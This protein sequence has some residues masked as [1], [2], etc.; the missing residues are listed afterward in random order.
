M[1][2][3]DAD[4]FEPDGEAGDEAVA[5]AEV[6]LEHGGGEFAFVQGNLDGLADGGILWVKAT[7]QA[8]GATAFGGEAFDG[9]LLRNNFVV[10]FGSAL[11]AEEISDF[12]D[13]VVGSPGTLDTARLAHHFGGKEQHVAFAEKFLGAALVEH[14]TGIHLGANRESNTTRNVG[15]DETGDDFD[16]WTLR[17]ED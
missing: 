11:G 2:A 9:N 4:F 16:F 10:V 1:G 12:I 17:G 15:L 13:I 5:F 7:T 8:A 3:D 6:G 14:D